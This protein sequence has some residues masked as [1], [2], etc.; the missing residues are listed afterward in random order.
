MPYENKLPLPETFAYPDIEPA[1]LAREE[2]E[3]DTHLAA[4]PHYLRRVLRP[5]GGS[6]GKW[7]EGKQFFF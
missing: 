4:W 3:D 2:D 6:A 5:A 7:K 1:I